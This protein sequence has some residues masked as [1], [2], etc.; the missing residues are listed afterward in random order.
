MRA[1]GCP[2]LTGYKHLAVRAGLRYY[3]IN[4][5]LDTTS[6]VMAYTR[7][8]W[9]P[10]LRNRSSSPCI[11]CQASA[12]SP[13]Q[14]L[15]AVVGDVSR[16]LSKPALIKARNAYLAGRSLARFL[17]R[18]R[19]ALINGLLVGLIAGLLVGLLVALLVGLL[20]GLLVVLSF[21]AV[22]LVGGALAYILL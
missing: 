18:Y 1:R 12:A 9:P 13:S 16:D 4:S 2:A 22:V 8:M 10:I 17:K 3:A 19:A 7:R 21:T 20:D 5:T 6:Q 15:V 14:T 11:S